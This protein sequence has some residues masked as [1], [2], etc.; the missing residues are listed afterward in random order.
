M[1]VLLQNRQDK[2]ISDAWQHCFGLHKDKKY[3]PYLHIIDNEC[4]DILKFSFRKYNIDFQRV[5]P[6]SHQQNSA[7][8]DIQTWKHHL[9]AGLETCEPNFPPAKWDCLMPQCNIIINILISSW[10]Q[11][12]LS[13]HACLYEN[14]DFSHSP[15]APPGTKVVI[16]ET[17]DQRDILAP[18]GIE[19]W[20]VGP[21][22][23][24]YRFHKWYILS[25]KCVQDVLTL[26]WFP[27]Q[28]PLPKVSTKDYLRQ[29]ASDML[30]ILLM[31][32]ENTIPSL[33]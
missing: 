19:G 14:F 1:S 12:K 17:V 7:E 25:T 15:L 22:I 6:H 2:S 20:Y 11:P 18:H 32:K 4:S 10:C 30:A 5:P 27:K 3:T 28:T 33:R 16:H 9:P 26:N 13:A 31:T 23:E 24:H 21:S 29:T 8:L